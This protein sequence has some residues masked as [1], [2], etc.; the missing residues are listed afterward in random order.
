MVAVTVF[1]AL[2]EGLAELRLWHIIVS[3]M[4]C[5]RS[6]EN[7]MN[8][9]CQM[10]ACSDNIVEGGVCQNMNGFSG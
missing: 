5:S 8:A 1:M 2:I 6:K 4:T 10:L 9:F 7:Q 3:T